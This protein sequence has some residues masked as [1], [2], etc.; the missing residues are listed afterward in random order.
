MKELDKQIVAEVAIVV[1]KSIQEYQRSHGKIAKALGMDSDI[2]CLNILE[3]IEK[4]VP[5]LRE[6]IKE[7][8]KEKMNKKM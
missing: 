6:A 4:A 5:I 1:G 3:A 8:I 2:W 7:K